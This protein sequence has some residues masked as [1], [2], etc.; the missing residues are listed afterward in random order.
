MLRLLF[1]AF[2]VTLGL[3]GP[4]MAQERILITSDWGTVTAELVDNNA[5]RALIQMAAHVGAR[6]F[7]QERPAI[8]LASASSRAAAPFLVWN[9]DFGAQSLRHLLP[10]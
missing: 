3:I 10:R 9:A 7:R 6:P 2:V 8:C 1:G 4:A 5:T